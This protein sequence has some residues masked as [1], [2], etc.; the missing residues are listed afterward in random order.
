MIQYPNVIAFFSDIHFLIIIFDKCSYSFI[1][2]AIEFLQ[3]QGSRLLKIAE[4]ERWPKRV[5]SAF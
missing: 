2:F 5:R 3:R 4:A 1:N